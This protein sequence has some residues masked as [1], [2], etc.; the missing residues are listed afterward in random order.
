[1]THT[2]KKMKQ[3]LLFIDNEGNKTS[4]YGYVFLDEFGHCIIIVY[5]ED[6]R[7]LISEYLNTP[8]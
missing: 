8:L 6:R 1:M 2:V 3:P 7:D 4:L 5:G